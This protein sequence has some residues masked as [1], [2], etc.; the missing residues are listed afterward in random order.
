MLHEGQLLDLDAKPLLAKIDEGLS[1]IYKPHFKEV[2]TQDLESLS[3][4]VTRRAQS[5]SH[6]LESARELTRTKSRI[7][8]QNTQRR[9]IS[10][11]PGASPSPARK[12]SLFTEDAPAATTKKTSIVGFAANLTDSQ[13][14]A[15]PPPNAHRAHTSGSKGVGFDH[16]SCEA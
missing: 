2:V 12:P 3:R 6:G 16:G 4:G 7:S 14:Q 11:A 9:K 13:S 1:N 10:N 15:C 8:R 5:V